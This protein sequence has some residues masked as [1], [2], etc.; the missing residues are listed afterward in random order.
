[1]TTQHDAVAVHFVA[2]LFFI[3]FNTSL[4]RSD[5]YFKQRVF[6]VCAVHDQVGFSLSASDRISNSTS[7]PASLL[8]L[9][10]PKGATSLLDRG[11][12]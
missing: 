2:E 9:Q 12:Y 7:F 3:V 5:R 8:D 6:S 11:S 1:M 4:V 10:F